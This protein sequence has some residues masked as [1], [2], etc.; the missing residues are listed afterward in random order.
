MRI[1]SLSLFLIVLG[2]I[3]P[4]VAQADDNVQQGAVEKAEQP[5]GKQGLDYVS[6]MATF[7]NF[8][9]VGT[10]TQT[11]NSEAAVLV[12]G[13]YLTD[14]FKIEMRFAK[15]YGSG[16]PYPGLEI[17]V[18]HFISW[19]MGVQY[20]WTDYSDIYAQFGFS[21][22]YGRATLGT[23]TSRYP[24]ID[25]GLLNSSFSPSW[26]LGTDVKVLSHTYLVFEAGKLH[27]DTDTKISTWQVNTGVRYEF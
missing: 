2:T 4:A 15:G 14:Y 24:K 20:P 25:S 19:Y 10:D 22:V 13:T 9:N 1:A 3:C 27:D 17:G 26:L 16:S 21:S 12:L 11:A 23:D 18:K 8:R 6:L 5:S 7:L